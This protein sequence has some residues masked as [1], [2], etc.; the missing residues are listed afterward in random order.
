[1]APPTERPPAPAPWHDL[2]DA[3]SSAFPITSAFP[4]DFIEGTIGLPYELKTAYSFVLDRIYMQSGKLPDDPRYIAG[5]FGVSVR[6][7]NAL[8]NGLIKAGKIQAENG[9]LTNYRAVSELESL[10]KLS[11]KQSEN[12][13]RPNKNNSLESPN[14]HHT[15]PEPE[16]DTEKKKETR[17]KR[18]SFPDDDFNRF[19]DAWPHKVGKPAARKAFPKALGVAASVEPILHGLRQYIRTK[20]PDRPWLNPATF[21]NQERWNDQPADTSANGGGTE[22]PKWQGPDGNSNSDP[23]RHSLPALH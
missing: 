17:A 23:P 1:V 7:W 18:A 16:P 14:H 4:R 22:L 5:L 15:E 10:T 2:G 8:R 21:L 13:A 3:V 19:W 9:Y 20:P 11:R 12:R 6:K